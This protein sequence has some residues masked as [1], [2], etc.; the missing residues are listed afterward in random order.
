MVRISATD[1]NQSGEVATI[2]KC[3]LILPPTNVCTCNCQ[4]HFT[5]CRNWLWRQPKRD[6][7]VS[8]DCEILEICSCAASHPQNLR[9]LGAVENG[10]V[11]LW[12]R[13]VQCDIN[14][15]Y[16]EGSFWKRRTLTRFIL[17][18]V[19]GTIFAQYSFKFRWMFVLNMPR[20]P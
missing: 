7:T 11:W 18:C 13:V 14:E 15:I 1:S 8:S 16:P 3:S 6:L 17:R 2:R 20:F 10:F 12:I 4:S 19:T 9:E 5:A